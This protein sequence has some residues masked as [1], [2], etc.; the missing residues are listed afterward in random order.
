ML[1]QTDD[2]AVSAPVGIERAFLA[3]IGTG[4]AF[5]VGAH[6]TM[7]AEGF[8]LFAMLADESG[9][10]ITYAEEL[11]SIGEEHS[12]AAEVAARLRAEVASDASLQQWTGASLENRDLTGVR[13]VVTRPRRR[14]GPLAS[15]LREL[16]ADPLLLPVIRIEPVADTA[17]FDY[18]LRELARGAFD[19]LVFT[20]ANAVEVCA[21][22][23]AALGLPRGGLKGVNVAAVGA[24][25]AAAAEAV[26]LSVRLVPESATAEKLAS[27]LIQR[28]DPGACVL[29]LRSAIGRD[30]LPRALRAAGLDVVDIP[31]Y[32]TVPEDD[33]EGETLERVRRGEMDVLTFSSPSGVRYFLELFGVDTSVLGDVPVVCAGPVSKQA[34]KD[35]G[36]AV[37]GIGDGAG[38]KAMAEAVLELWRTQTR[39]SGVS[40]GPRF[41]MG[42]AGGWANERSSD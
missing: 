23:M 24:S 19:W 10:R 18:R 22:R 13:V 5:P 30:E 36:F 29:Y 17:D 34:A 31:V 27:D 4:C 14:A 8:R 16:G 2:A 32:R 35:A 39:A 15:A 33:L 21:T 37:V 1:A 3:A 6:A 20:S 12:H 42:A 11:L 9:E 38:A 28:A 7:T 41:V 26:G 25:T 40:S